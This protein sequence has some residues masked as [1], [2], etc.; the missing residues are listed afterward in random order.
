MV[1]SPNRFHRLKLTDPSFCPVGF[2]RI[3]GSVKDVHRLPFLEELAAMTPAMMGIQMM[4]H[5]Q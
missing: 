5:V 3:I 2:C 4:S 1:Q